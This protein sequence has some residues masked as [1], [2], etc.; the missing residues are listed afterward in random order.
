MRH[1]R[2]SVCMCVVC[3]CVVCVCVRV[4]VRACMCTCGVHVCVHACVCV[5]IRIV[6][7]RLMHPHPLIDP[8]TIEYFAIPIFLATGVHPSSNLASLPHLPAGHNC[9][10]QLYLVYLSKSLYTSVKVCTPQ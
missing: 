6:L 3:M 4:C 9:T 2:C 5:E 7:L 10:L 8:L 1:F